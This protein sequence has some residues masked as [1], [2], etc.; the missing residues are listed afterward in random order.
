MVNDFDKL[1][2][3]FGK[4]FLSF[5]NMAVWTDYISKSEQEIWSY[6]TVIVSWIIYWILTEILERKCGFAPQIFIADKLTQLAKRIEDHTTHTTHATKSNGN[7]SI[8]LCM[9]DAVSAN[10][11]DENENE[12]E[13]AK[14]EV[15]NSSTVNSVRNNSPPIAKIKSRPNIQ[16]GK[17]HEMPF[18]ITK[19]LDADGKYR[20]TVRVSV[21]IIK[22]LWILTLNL[23]CWIFTF[24]TPEFWYQH[25]WVQDHDT[26]YYLPLRFTY[27]L[28]G[29]FYVWELNVNRYGRLSWSVVAHHLMA[30]YV[31]SSTIIFGTFTPM[32]SMYGLFGVSFTFPGVFAFTI[33]T[34][35]LLL[36]FC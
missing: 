33:R 20:T 23:T 7:K 11:F 35:L 5:R 10:Q 27:A 6:L 29:S 22:C 21:N 36:F 18:R 9:V 32:A 26:V 25:I 17:S 13:N 14:N 12:N 4:L 3:S 24:I 16:T 30:T 2:F 8:E 19:S 34:C 15:E 28:L 31:V 1:L